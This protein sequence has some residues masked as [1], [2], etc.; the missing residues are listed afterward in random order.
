MCLFILKNGGKC[1]SSAVSAQD[2]KQTIFQQHFLKLK[3]TFPGPLATMHCSFC[4]IH[5]TR[6]MFFLHPAL[7][8]FVHLFFDMHK[9]KENF[10]CLILFYK[11][12][13]FGRAGHRQWRKWATATPDQPATKTRQPIPENQEPTTGHQPRTYS[14]RRSAI[15][16]AALDDR[17]PTTSTQTTITDSYTP[18]TNK[19]TPDNRQPTTDS[20]KKNTETLNP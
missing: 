3:L 20:S 16:Q 11:C 15:R 12:A 8:S 18:K 7:P 13:I 19:P 6:V 10:T 5:M 4:S 9:E 1:L 2:S 17:Y 14:I